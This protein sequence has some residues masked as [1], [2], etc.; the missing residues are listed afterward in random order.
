MQIAKK[1]GV[2]ISIDLADPALVN[3]N[4]AELRK[5]VKE[6]ADIIF[7]NEHEAE[8]FTGKKEEEAL[9]EIYEMCEIAIVK[10]GAEGSLIKANGM[11]YKIPVYKTSVVNTNGAGDMYAAGI[12]YGIASNMDM[13]KAGHLASY[14]ASRVVASADARLTKDM[15]EEVRKFKS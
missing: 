8:A 13:E 10:L 9:H 11:I 14:A 5:L 7:V 4:L 12:L 15:K 1:N 3:R 6:F 2:K